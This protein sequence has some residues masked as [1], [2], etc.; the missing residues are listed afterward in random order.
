MSGNATWSEILHENRQ[1]SIDELIDL[2]RIPSV[3][4]AEAHIGDVLRAADWV[5]ERMKRAGLENVEVSPT[6]P[7]ACVYGDWLHSPGRPTVL[8][9]GHF[10]VQPADPLELWDSPPFEPVIADG[11]LYARGAADMKGNLLLCLLAVEA[12]LVADG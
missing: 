9:Y 1:R 12:L 7:H 5:A 8:L 11:R 10:D 3:S 6:G 4:A 2:L